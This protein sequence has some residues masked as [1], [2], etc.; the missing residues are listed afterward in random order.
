MKAKF[1]SV[2]LAVVMLFSIL[3]V[4]ISAESL[5]KVPDGYVGVYT[6]DDLYAVR[7]NPSGKY[8]LMND[9]VFEDSDYEKGGDFYNSGK[10][11]SPIGTQLTKFTG[12]FDGNGYS[13]VNLKINNPDASYQGLF[14]YAS[15]AK[16]FDVILIDADIV[17]GDYTGGIVGYFYGSSSRI[18]SGCSCDG[19]V[20]GKNSVGGI[21]GYLTYTS[22]VE[23]CINLAQVTG[24]S[25]VGGITGEIYRSSYA[26]VYIKKCINS[27]EII[28]SGT[29]AGGIVGKGSGNTWY[30]E[31]CYN[32]GD[33]SAKN[34][35][36]GISG[37]D[38]NQYG[39]ISWSYSIGNVTAE[40]SFGGCFGNIPNSVTFCYYLDEAV[41]E[42]DCLSGT[43]KSD[44]Q[45]SKQGTFEQWDFDTVWTMEGRDDYFYPELR[46]VDLVFPDEEKS[47]ITVK[48]GD[49]TGR[50]GETV[51]VYV[52]ID[53]VTD[54]KSM[55]IFDI[56]YDT[57]KLTLVDGKWLDN[58]AV[59]EDW[60][61]NDKTGAMA[62]IDNTTL[63]GNVFAL[64]FKITDTLDEY[65]VEID[66]VVRIKTMI[67]NQDEKFLSVK[68]IP[69]LLT[70]TNLIKG[71]VTGDSAVNSNDAI[72]LLYHTLIPERYT[73]NQNCDFN[74][75]GFVNSNDA[76]YLLYYTLI[77]DRYPL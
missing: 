18:L 13:V 48:V 45:L 37:S 47:E 22:V 55:S 39:K 51:T 64:T 77:P 8:I 14:G 41:S 1:L 34:N 76:I 9:I 24:E 23:N 38:Y 50:P 46:D 5:V 33:V 49:V 58:R 6:K 32:T 7:E 74:K 59:L 62:F 63:S 27:G 31:N 42:P 28:C 35:A 17:G 65:G 10:G 26:D 19:Y 72:H 44:D 73:V 15:D 57:E 67:K 40:S 21:V 43:V 20:S 3:S 69:G 60:N 61:L 71:D 11:W 52:S 66:C 75:D 54:V 25:C 30:I 53:T 12:I 56:D 29:K 36:G 2:F 68:V 4:G 16:I 70:V